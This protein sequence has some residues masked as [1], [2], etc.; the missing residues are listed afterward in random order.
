MINYIQKAT[1]IKKWPEKLKPTEWPKDTLQHMTRSLFVHAVFPLRAISDIPMWPSSLKEAHV[2]ESGKSRHSTKYYTRL[3]DATDMHVKTIKQMIEV[4]NHA[5]TID[6]IGGIG[7]YFNT[8]T[9]MFHIDMRAGRLV[10]ICTNKGDY[11]Y[12]ENDPVAF[13]IALGL[14]ISQCNKK[15]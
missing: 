11:I 13:Y 1:E 10:W 3:S 9:P 7:V 14:E 4:M 6:A 15:H 5:E 12:R 2:R 8:N